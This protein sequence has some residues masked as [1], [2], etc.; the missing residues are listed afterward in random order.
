MKEDAVLTVFMSSKGGSGTTVTACASALRAASHHG[1]AL[2]IDLCGDVPAALGMAEPNTPG[3]NEWLAE[4]QTADGESLMLLGNSTNNGLIVIHRGGKFVEGQPRWC[5]LAHV[6]ST[7]QMPVFID[8]GTGYVPDELR[9]L[10]THVILVTRQC[11]LSLRRATLL[12]K[13]TGVVV[14]E[15]EGRALQAKDIEYVIGAPVLSTIPVTAAMSRAV[16]AGLFT[17]RYEDV[18]GK[19]LPDLS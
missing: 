14:V 2:F 1:S 6:L 18:M 8:A 4:N 10:A 5:E 15:E 13:P 17:T 9:S 3:I 11:Y 19:H 16:D 7:I 12:P